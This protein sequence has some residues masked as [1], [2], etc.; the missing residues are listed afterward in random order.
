MFWLYNLLIFLSLPLFP[1]LKSRVKKRGEVGIKERF[2]VDFEGARGRVILHAS[3]TGEVN[4]V[5]PLVKK[6][7]ENVALTVFTDYGLERARKLYPRVP[8]RVLPLDLYPLTLKFLEKTEPKAFLIYE[9]E[10]WPSLLKALSK[11]SVPT[12]FVSGKIGEKTYRRLRF[13]RSSLKS[14]ISDKVFLA[15]REIDAER[16]L[17]L[18]FKRVDVVGDLKFDYEPPK[19]R[20][21]LEVEGDRSL[22]VW[23]S[24]HEGEEE[25]AVRVHR[26]LKREVP[27]LLTVIAPRHTGRRLKIGGSV[28]FRSRSKRVKR[29]TEFYIID[30]VGEL[31]SI[32]SY[33]TV[34]VIGGSFVKGIGGHNPV[35][36]VAFKVPTL[37]GRYGEDF[38]EIAER[39]RIPL[40]SEGELYPELLKLLTNQNLRNKIGEE[41]YRLWQE[42]RGVADRIVRILGENVEL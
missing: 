33:A 24:T 14:L 37:M 36:P 29:E 22:V 40:L 34:A 15:R 10:I 26:K 39:L 32:Y 38:R 21:P 12:F 6:L 5:K 31:P 3:S 11:R 35:E 27:N 9:T 30:T 7:G 13:F 28:E 17:E 42:E 4:S 2:S 1:V 16:A 18:G 20:V 41:S 23:G 8:S 19:E 25:L